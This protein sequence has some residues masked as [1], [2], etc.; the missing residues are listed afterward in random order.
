MNSEIKF[1]FTGILK[2]ASDGG[3]YRRLPERS[4]KSAAGYDF[5]NPVDVT[6]PAHSLMLVKTGIKSKFPND[7]ALKLLE[8]LQTETLRGMY[9]SWLG[10]I[11]EYRKRINKT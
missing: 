4:T 1:E 8:D 10:G 9:R 3:P 7:I 2:E 11:E 6:I 5:F